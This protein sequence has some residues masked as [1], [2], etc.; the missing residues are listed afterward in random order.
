M[1]QRLAATHLRAQESATVSRMLAR[2]GMSRTDAVRRAIALGSGSTGARV[3]SGAYAGVVGA[4]SAC[5]Q[6][7]NAAAHHANAAA[8]RYANSVRLRPGEV[9]EMCDEVRLAAEAADAAMARTRELDDACARAREAR[10]VTIPDATGRAADALVARVGEEEYEML[11]LQ[12]AASG[13]SRSAWLRD[14]VML[15]ALTW[16]DVPDGDVAVAHAVDVAR[17]TVAAQRWDTNAAQVRAA[18]E[19]LV[20][21]RSRDRSID[22]LTMASLLADRERCVDDARRCASRM[23]E[24]VD[25]MLGRRP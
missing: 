24:A 22:P 23:H 6:P 1:P 14:M 16:P 20:R 7:L 11:A 15:V 13:V 3:R 4:L 5:G 21:A 12:A 8:A 2:A 18:M 17:L 9:N 10:V 19:R 25:P